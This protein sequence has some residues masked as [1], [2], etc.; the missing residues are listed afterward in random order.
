MPWGIM[1]ILAFG[2]VSGRWVVESRRSGRDYHTSQGRDYYATPGLLLRL[3]T[4]ALVLQV[5]CVAERMYKVWMA[6]EREP[7][8]IYS[9]FREAMSSVVGSNWKNRM[10]FSSILNH[11]IVGTPLTTKER[12]IISPKASRLYPPMEK[13]VIHTISNHEKQAS[14]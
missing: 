6:E 12:F 3:T 11:F 8:I 9:S 14:E 1:E 2:N 13:I 4:H 7:N 10:V 5:R